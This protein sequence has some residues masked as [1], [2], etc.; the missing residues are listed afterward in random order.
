MPAK[1]RV[2]E[3]EMNFELAEL[4]DISWGGV[5]VRWPNPFP[6]GT[7]LILQFFL[8]EDSVVLEIWGTVVRVRTGRQDKP[9]G[10]GIKFDELD[11]SARSTIQKMVYSYLEPYIPRTHKDQ[12]V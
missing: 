3:T 9:N 10:M 5:F 11:D 1:F 2:A 6:K 7:R 4:E 12:A 8:A